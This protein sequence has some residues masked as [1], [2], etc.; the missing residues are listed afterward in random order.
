MKLQ[1]GEF[2]NIQNGP[3]ILIR[4]CEARCYLIELGFKYV[5]G[6][7]NVYLKSVF[8]HPEELLCNSNILEF[9]FAEMD[10]DAIDQDRSIR[11]RWDWYGWMQNG[12]WDISLNHLPA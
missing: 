3:N 1:N 10:L 12:K 8:G 6:L 11:L 9:K 2:S 5:V 4:F 7:K